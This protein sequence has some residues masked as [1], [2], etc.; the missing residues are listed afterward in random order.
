[1]VMEVAILRCETRSRAARM[2]ITGA[3]EPFLFTVANYS[4]DRLGPAR[5]RNVH[6]RL[7]VTTRWLVTLP[8]QRRDVFTVHGRDARQLFG[9]F[10]GPLER[11][12]IE[13]VR[14][15][16]TALFVDPHGDGDS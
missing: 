8:A 10:D 12:A 3:D 5:Q 11:R 6:S 2:M 1:L 14:G 9:L 7:H 13:V 4:V 15:G 16:R